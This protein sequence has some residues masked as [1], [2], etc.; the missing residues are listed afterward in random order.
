MK[1]RILIT[2][3]STVLLVSLNAQVPQGINYQALALDGSNEPIRN[4]TISVRLMILSSLAPEVIEW[5]E[6][7]GT[8]STNN[9]GLF[10]LVLGQG[11]KQGTPVASAFSLV[12]WSKPELYIRTFVT[13]QSTEHN[14]GT[15]RL[16]SVPYAF[17]AGSVT[18]S[19]PRLQVEGLPSGTDDALFEVKNKEGKTVFAVYNQGIR[20]YVGSGES[21]AVKGGF[22]IGS[23]DESKLNQDL[24]VVNSDCVR[25]YLDDNPAKAVKGGFAIGSF[26]ES[27]SS[28][29]LFKVSTDSI[30]MY[31]DNTPGKAVKGGF[32][33]GSF[34]ESKAPSGSFFD[35]LPVSTGIVNPSEPRILWYPLKNAFLAGQVLITD[36]AKVGLNSM[37][38]GYE[39]RAEG[40][41]SQALG[42]KSQAVGTNSTAIGK[43]ATAYSNNSF[44][45][46]ENAYAG[47]LGSF[48]LGIGTRATGLGSFAL[49]FEGKDSTNT[50]TG[51]TEASGEYSM[52]FG[53][54]ARSKN[55]GSLAFGTMSEANFAYSSAIGYQTKADN[56][57][58]TA[59]GYKTVASGIYSS[60]FGF[61]SM[62]IG[63]SS[64]ALGRGTAQGNRSVALGNAYAQGE[65]SIAMG[66]SSVAQGYTSI[67][68]GYENSAVGGYSTAFGAGTFANGSYSFSSGYGTIAEADYATVTG[69][70][71]I[72]FKVL[73]TM[74]ITNPL[75]NPIFEVGNGTSSAR[76]NA[77]S[78]LRNGQVI[79]GTHNGLFIEDQIMFNDPPH[80]VYIKGRKPTVSDPYYGLFVQGN[81]GMEGNI[82]PG[83]VNTYSIGAASSVWNAVHAS[84]Y[85]GNGTSASFYADLL[86]SGTRSLG[87]ATY[88]WNSAYI[89]T[90]YG[91]SS[92]I[93]VF[94]ATVNPSGTRDLGSTTAYWNALYA[95]QLNI[96]GASSTREI[97]FTKSGTYA[98]AIGY[99]F[100]SDYIYFYQGGNVAIKGGE[101]GVGT[102]APK[103]TVHAAG[104][105]VLGLDQN[106][107]KFIFHS[108]TNANGDFLNITSDDASGN[109]AWSNGIMLT[110]TGQVIIGGGTPG[111]HRLYVTGTAY[112]TGGWTGSDIK[113][114]KN[115][116]PIT[117]TLS[118]VIRLNGVTYDWRSDEYP[119][120]GFDNHTQVGLIAQDVEKVF[121]LLVRTDTD[122]SKAVSYDKLS[123]ILVEAIKEQQSQ[124]ETYKSEVSALRTELEMLRSEMAAVKQL[125]SGQMK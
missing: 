33:I 67:S 46:G 106:N 3:C 29:D 7:H 6:L 65:Y 103:G 88:R 13:H 80:T 68:A 54:G 102:T 23:F 43:G 19:L 111:T 40:E 28:Q 22:A 60:A 35:I 62:A 5:H 45:F 124:I 51:V 76:T 94:A 12:N 122:G 53:M 14:M 69:F 66:N 78:V 58:A 77:I 63:E 115:I 37:S 85:Y 38:I 27:K 39:T 108:R 87:N 95:R 104:D 79:I 44:A 42:Y 36:P 4:S 120:M 119:D 74:D 117:N 90:Y 48:A 64:V 101:L 41:Y 61:R 70:W 2:L 50:L 110:R 10:S 118:E 109:W 98:G 32:A 15:S 59:V 86:P 56:W 71:N 81:I 57:Y 125:V 107:K 114:K 31:L 96:D 84:N 99:N 25:V 72:G 112:S 105:L 116:V 18:G 73:P 82:I 21:K 9:S 97:R 55:R 113:W 16:L 121:P 8:V 93:A 52:A 75:F 17:A 92:N 123:V 91:N 26:D 47:G 1:T 83:V 20:M 34:D 11:V 30:R 24:L 49:G 100:D 89:N